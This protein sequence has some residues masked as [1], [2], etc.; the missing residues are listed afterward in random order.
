M[1]PNIINTDEIENDTSIPDE[2]P[3]MTWGR[4]YCTLD[5]AK[6][7]DQ[8]QFEQAVYTPQ[9]F[10]PAALLHVRPTEGSPVLP[11]KGRFGGAGATGAHNARLAELLGW[12]DPIKP[13]PPGYETAWWIG[14]YAEY[15]LWGNFSGNLQS[16]HKKIVGRP[17]KGTENDWTSVD[18]KLRD[19]EIAR[20]MGVTRQVAWLQRQRHDPNIKDREHKARRVRDTMHRMNSD[21]EAQKGGDHGKQVS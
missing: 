9:K 4:I 12:I 18:W 1:I 10:L 6:S 3:A 15:R 13:L 14:Y 8:Q 21:E 7:F 17:V 11:T 16:V 2:N 5:H 19:S 20:Q